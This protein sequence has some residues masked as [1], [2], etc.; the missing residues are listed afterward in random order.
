MNNFVNCILI[1]LILFICSHSIAKNNKIK[2]E[3]K[4]ASP[5]IPPLPFGGIDLDNFWKFNKKDL[6]DLTI[7]KNDKNYNLN[8]K[9]FIGSYNDNSIGFGYNL[10]KYTFNIAYNPNGV[11]D[12]YSLSSNDLRIVTPQTTQKTTS[13]LKLKNWFIYTDQFDNLVFYYSKTNN[14]TINSILLKPG[15][16]E[17]ILNKFSYVLS[18]DKM[19]SAIDL[20]SGIQLGSF[21]IDVNPD[22]ES[23]LRFY[24]KNDKRNFYSYWKLCW[25][26]DSF[27]SKLN[28]KFGVVK[29]LE[30]GST[31]FTNTSTDKLQTKDKLFIQT[32]PFA[33]SYDYPPSDIIFTT[34]LLDT[35][36]K[37]N[38]NNQRYEIKL[39]SISKTNFTFQVFNWWTSYLNSIRLD[40]SAVEFLNPKNTSIP[41][42][43]TPLAYNLTTIIPTNNITDKSG[44]VSIV[45]SGIFS[46]VC[47]VINK[48][49]ICTSFIP[50]RTTL[51]P[52]PD[53]I[54]P[55]IISIDTGTTRSDNTKRYSID[56]LEINDFGF[57][58]QITS[59]WTSYI[60]AIKINWQAF[61]ITQISDCLYSNWVSGETITINNKQYIVQRRQKLSTSPLICKSLITE[62]NILNE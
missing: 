33:K 45:D 18:E 62:R 7:I 58:I 23:E 9:W 53:F 8:N 16:S 44:N 38:D 4:F 25:D 28:N 35:G 14:E 10:S 46:S 29:F 57:K 21:T 1:L 30:K 55:T 34:S 42:F 13:P 26:G 47:G 15:S 17:F 51:S 5:S 12:I 24:N 32:I 39:L 52:P 31:S 20:S 40:W 59:W 11:D 6:D 27:Y 50:F 36:T 43:S 19:N 54:I 37:R 49:N 2:S 48:D 60:N 22:D 3:E 56:V 41:I 61:K